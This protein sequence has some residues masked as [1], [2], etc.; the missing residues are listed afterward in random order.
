MRCPSCE[1]ENPG[2]ETYCAD[3]GALLTAAPVVLEQRQRHDLLPLGEIPGT[4]YIVASAR[5]DGAFNVYE[6]I[7]ARDGKAARVLEDAEAPPLEKA[8]EASPG[9]P[10]P[11]DP[12]RA[13][14]AWRALQASECPH[15]WAVSD[16]FYREGRGFLVGDPLPQCALQPY[17]QDGGPLPHDDVVAIGIATLK[18]LSELHGRGFLH[19]GVH[20][21][22]I[23]IDDGGLALLDGYERLARIDDLPAVCSV[24]EGYSAPEAFGVGGSP[25]VASDVY[26]VGATLYFLLSGQSPAAVSREQ[27]FF[28]P[29]LRTHVKGVPPR[30]EAAVMKAVS[31]DAR[32]RF[33]SADEMA[34]ALEEVLL[35]GAED[36]AGDAAPTTAGEAPPAPA[37]PPAPSPSEAAPPASEPA[38][39]G[40]ASTPQ[41][42]WAPGFLPCVIGM[43]SHVGCVRSV[44]Q[45]SL[46]VTGFSAWEHSV[47]TQ[48]L[49]VVVADGMGGEA[50]GD[51]ASSL[52]IR[53]MASH[54]LASCIPVK[55]G[56]DTSRL[57]PT[58]TVPRLEELVH[59]AIETA[60]RC[61]FDY[62][63]QDE[64]RRGMGS[65]LT[66]LMIDW[67]HAVFGHAGDTRAYLYRPA[68]QQ[69]D[70]V[71]EDHSL[72]GK[73]VR[74]GQLTREEARTSPQ[75]SYLY[76]ALG[77]QGELEVDLY[78]RELARGDRLLLCSDG[79]WEYFS[80]DE[81]IGFMR[82]GDDPQATCERLIEETLRRGAD[83]NATAI[84]VHIL[85]ASA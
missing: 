25:C 67:P 72:V 78:T 11:E 20:P 43:K 22:H 28:F 54:V 14:T 47:P 73:L 27:F 35:G 23:F 70:Q 63:R 38:S 85:P 10:H 4:G 31:K 3:C 66:A 68:S 84:I 59:E 13:A 53:S 76:R 5:V 40:E 60:N 62:S 57:R 2:E 44:N 55:T 79:V 36:T 12:S 46:L 51:K 9:Q 26:G 24:T 32:N 56:T 64:S 50:E 17:R 82:Q 21:S 29:P 39:A 49:L 48:A 41:Q 18:A 16:F 71:T 77:T 6:A 61:V 65:T 80:E 45:D 74:I 42:P 30:L 8:D 69:I 1:L 34:D 58:E 19:L 33:S 83:D 37:D 75:R 52:A 15:L 7:R 81:I